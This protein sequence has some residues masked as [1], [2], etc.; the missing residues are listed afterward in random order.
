[1]RLLNT[2][3]LEFE[4]SFKAPSNY[5]ILSHRWG[6]LNEEVSYEGYLGKSQ[7]N[8][9]GY[10]KI[11]KFC[12]IARGDGYKLA[13]IDTCCID[14]RSSAELTEA[15]NSM[16]RWYQQS[17]RCYVYLSY[18]DTSD[19]LQSEW[20]KRG[21][22]LQ[23]LI[24][25]E[26]LVFYDKNWRKIGNKKS[27]KIADKVVD[28]TKLPR[29][30]ITSNNLQPYSVGVKMSWMSGRTTTLEEDE[31]YCLLGLFDVN[32]PMIHGEGRVAF[33][34]LQ[35]IIFERTGDETIFAFISDKS[36][37]EPSQ[38]YQSIFATSPK[39]FRTNDTEDGNIG[40]MRPWRIQPPRFTVWGLEVTSNA[41]KIRIHKATTGEKI[42]T[43]DYYVVILACGWFDQSE[44]LP[45]HPCYLALIP[46]EQRQ[47]NVFECFRVPLPSL[48][49][50]PV[51]QIV[52]REGHNITFE[53]EK[54]QE[55]TF[56]IRIF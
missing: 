8:R 46:Y 32:M 25:P 31:A 33:I 36:T 34:R 11:S 12:N 29:E 24:A 51:E 40:E 30:L 4:E 37:D 35:Q 23:E 15:I 18:K 3:T 44:K 14:K 38:G 27:K 55:T 50:D 48:R 41:E 39:Q 19:W 2:Y 9:A 22:T 49:V 21:W 13:W 42:V 53:R 7:M 56:Y 5:A 10:E 54:V 43:I 45:R 20:W 52:A 16:Y 26:D 47:A 17:G 28:A 6:S 1:M